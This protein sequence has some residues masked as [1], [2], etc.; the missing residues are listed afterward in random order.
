MSYPFANRY[1]DGFPKRMT[2]QIYRSVAFITG[3]IAGALA[4]A[5]LLDPEKGLGLEITPDKTALFYITV[6][7]S[8]WAFARGN[9]SD[10]EIV[11]DPEFSLRNV[12]E[13]THYFPDHWNDRMYSFDVKQEFS[14]LYKL[15]IINFLDDLV[16][17]LTAPLVLLISLPKCSDQI[18]D[19]F[20]E[21]TVHVDGLG[22]V[23]SFA[24]FDF[25][26]GVGNKRYQTAEADVRDDYYST[27]HGKMAASYYGF[28]DNYVLNPKSGIPTHAPLGLRHQFHPP[29]AFPGL[30]SS[31]PAVEAAGPK[32]NHVHKTRIM[33]SGP[34][35]SG[36]PLRFTGSAAYPSPMASMLLDPRHQPSSASLTARS[37][38]IARQ[39]RGGYQGEES[40]IEESAEENTGKG[41]G[42]H[43]TYDDIHESGG[44]LGESLWQTSPAKTLSRENSAAQSEEPEA[45]VLGL[46]YQFQQ[47]HRNHRPGGVM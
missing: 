36:R 43:V 30:N 47:A 23:C 25:K 44:V 28:I 12:I 4:L 19:F 40:I 5:S 37:V 18:V 8:I 3:A 13:Y 38:H 2:E 11:A 24:L 10:E 20:R 9:I 35:S 6:F 34:Q 45:G 46:I 15:R 42:Q 27:K 41:A 32:D 1:L 31:A 14:G 7:G 29:P 17:I 22:Y 26:A 33:S 21:F 16:G 39:S